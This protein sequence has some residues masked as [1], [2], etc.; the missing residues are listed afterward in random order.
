MTERTAERGA[1]AGKKRPVSPLVRRR[2]L[3]ARVRA[4]VQLIFFLF[5]PSAFTAAFSGVKYLFTQLGEG[6]PVEL[7]SFVIVL[8]GL[9]GFTIVFGRF[10][11][12]WLCAFGALGDAL[13]ALYLWGCKRLKRKPVKLP[14]SLRGRE[15]LSWSK[16][17]LL[18]FLAILGYLGKL[19]LLQGT[20]PWEVFSLLRAGNFHLAGHG[21]G[22]GIL[23]VLVVLMAVQERFF[24]RNLCPMG[25]VFSLLP[26]LPFF[27]LHRDRE[28]CRKGCSACEK[29]CPSDVQLP[30]DGSIAVSGDCFQCQKCLDVCPAQNN[31]TGL[32]HALRG[33]ELWFSLLR[34]GLALVVFVL[35]GI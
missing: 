35:L 25:A 11:C 18:F 9:C 8:L 7:T 17:G 2:R 26:V 20:S 13:H 24:C 5:F 1:A 6:K 31:H 29:I 19:S 16:Y 33:S 28:H 23:T 34:A 32:T 27:S 21:V 15:V 14:L 12:G 3:H 30:D 4:G 10:F 22:I